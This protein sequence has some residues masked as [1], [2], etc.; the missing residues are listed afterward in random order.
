MLIYPLF[1]KGREKFEKKKGREKDSGGDEMKHTKRTF[2][3][4]RELAIVL[5]DNSKEHCGTV[6]ELFGDG[7]V[8]LDV[9]E[10]Q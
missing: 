9:A 8:V 5:I 3:H 7:R 6:A 2:A 4:G 10:V 1:L